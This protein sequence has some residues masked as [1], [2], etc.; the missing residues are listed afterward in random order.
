MNKGQK[1]KWDGSTCIEINVTAG[2]TTYSDVNP[3]VC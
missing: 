3:G 1:C 2:C